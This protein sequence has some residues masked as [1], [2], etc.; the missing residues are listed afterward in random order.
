MSGYTEA[1]GSFTIRQSKTHSYIIGQK[2]E[3]EVLEG[4]RKRLG[5]N[6]SVREATKKK[7]NL[8]TS[9]KEPLERVIS[10]YETYP[11]LGEKRVEFER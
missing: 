11:L 5:I 10:Q 6:A 1:S 7:Y 4:I 2:E 9:S 3:R 8:E